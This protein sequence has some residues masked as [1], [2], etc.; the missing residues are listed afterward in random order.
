MTTLN[1]REQHSRVRSF[2]HGAFGALPEYA[3]AH[4]ALSALVPE[5]H[6]PTLARSHG[7]GAST[8]R[9]P[10]KIDSRPVSHLP[11]PPVQVL[12]GTNR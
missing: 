9:L 8:I 11:G 10:I 4:K 1:R 12:D 2:D 6:V 7:E 3:A 5:V